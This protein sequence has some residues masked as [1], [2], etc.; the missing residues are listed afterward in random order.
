MYTFWAVIQWAG[1]CLGKEL[2]NDS[3]ADHHQVYNI[4]KLAFMLNPVITLKDTI[5]S[6]SSCQ[7]HQSD[8]HARVKGM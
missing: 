1:R 7:Q 6:D 2:C 3:E 5:M 4:Y 8:I